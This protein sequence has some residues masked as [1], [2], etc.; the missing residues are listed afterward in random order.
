MIEGLGIEMNV[1]RWIVPVAGGALLCAVLLHAQEPANDPKDLGLTER[2]STRLAQLDVTVTGP[3]EAISRLTADDFELVV[4]GRPYDEFLVDSI[5]PPPGEPPPA[6]QIAT[7]PAANEP[8]ATP[9]PTPRRRPSNFLFYFDQH[10]LTAEGRAQAILTAR[11]LVDELVVEGNRAMVVSSGEETVVFAELTG[12]R[13][14]LREAIKAVERD[15]KQWDTWAELEDMRVREVLSVL[16]DDV[17]RAI[18]TARRHARDERWHTERSLRIFSTVLPRLSDLDPPKI[19]IYFADTLRSNAGEHYMSYF[20][21]DTNDARLVAGELDALS[22]RNPYDALIAEAA[23][24]GI[25][26]YTVQAQ[27]MTVES[28]I[29]SRSAR[30][31][32]LSSNKGARVKD[33]QSALSGMANETG[34]QAFL[35]GVWANKIAKRIRQDLSCVYL[36]SFDPS[37]LPEDRPLPVKLAVARSGVT[38]R[39]RGQIVL[40][41]DAKRAT[42][43]LLSAFALPAERGDEEPV[44][45]IVIPTGYREGKFTALVQMVV[46]PSPLSGVEWDL[47]TSMVSRGKVREDV[48][49][50]V[51]ISGAGV[52]VVLETEMEFASGPF[53][54]IMVAR[55]TRS[56]LI[57]T[58]KLDG[59][60]PDPGEEPITFGPVAILQPGS[61]AFVKDGQHRPKGALGRAADQWVRPELATALISII[62]RQGTKPAKD[63]PIRVERRI[64][65]ESAAD[66]PPMELD[67]GEER[68][69]PFRD[70]I[71]A[72]TMTSG[73]F[74]YEIQALAGDKVLRSAT[75]ELLVIGD[76]A[77]SGE[78]AVP[79][80]R[81]DG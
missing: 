16:N 67:F 15:R 81:S 20:A 8:T 72:G 1:K 70:L 7:A 23:A 12:D 62:C 77:T 22:A 37:G 28:N 74:T 58:G 63:G 25:R 73:S 76:G 36:L 78:E 52:P 47:G 33:A 68:C 10:N 14:A 32:S 46:P 80:A 60:W 34:G 53:E 56:D 69:L 44:R 30:P 29:R 26:L 9:A 41:S 17:S 4:G 64:V 27:G 19:V 43:R 6:T 42:S 3:E 18:S 35:N 75:R 49:E 71:P 48:A 45:G 51:S 2:A 5:C 38:T 57:T 61:G 40:Q 66:F 50:R 79:A 65:G 39:T 13:A 21:R 24:H 59:D 11:D 54:L 55:E 31:M